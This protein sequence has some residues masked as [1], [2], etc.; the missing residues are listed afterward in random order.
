MSC[1]SGDGDRENVNEPLTT[2]VMSDKT[3]LL[4]SYGKIFDVMEELIN[5]A[6]IDARHSNE[7]NIAPLSE[8]VEK[9]GYRI[10][11]FG[12]MDLDIICE[13]DEKS[14]KKYVKEIIE[15]SINHNGFMVGSGNSIPDYVPAE[16]Y[17]AMIGQTNEIRGIKLKI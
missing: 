15:Y 4:H 9:Y 16:G 5:I 12:G 8:W 3:F 17:L 10:G 1:K 11:N 7:D 2:I 6:K 14:I 13:N